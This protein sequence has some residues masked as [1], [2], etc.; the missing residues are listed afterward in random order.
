MMSEETCFNL[1]LEFLLLKHL[2]GRGQAYQE[3]CGS[4]V[5][6]SNSRISSSSSINMHEQAQPAA[7]CKKHS[8]S[9]SSG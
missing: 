6:L 1:Y 3:V 2:P 7:L 5:F 4:A 8:W 9:W